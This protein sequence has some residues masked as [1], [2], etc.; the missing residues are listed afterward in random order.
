M[1]KNLIFLS[2]YLSARSRNCNNEVIVYSNDLPR[3]IKKIIYLNT[4]NLYLETSIF[5]H[6]DHY[7]GILLNRSIINKLNWK[8]KTD[9]SN[10]Y[11]SFYSNGYNFKR[12][13]QEGLLDE[14]VYSEYRASIEL[15]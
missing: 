14:T 12:I 15:I 6:F 9:I 11:P 3:Y 8:T 13:R 7:I 5:K 4:I 2:R 10:K 1:G